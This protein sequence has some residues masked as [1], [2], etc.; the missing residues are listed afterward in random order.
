MKPKDF[1]LMANAYNERLIDQHHIARKQA[2]FSSPV[3][4]MSKVT[5][6]KFIRD[7]WPLPDEAE[8]GKGKTRRLLDRLK[9][10][11]EKMN[12]NGKTGNTG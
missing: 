2:Y 6:A 8:E 7:Y 5:W 4:F 10:E 11:K 9:Q 1:I 12:G 3:E